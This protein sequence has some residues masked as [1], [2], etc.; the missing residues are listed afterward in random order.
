MAIRL[1][2]WWMLPL[3]P[4]FRDWPADAERWR[5][6]VTKPGLSRLLLCGACAWWSGL[7]GYMSDDHQDHRPLGMGQVVFLPAVN[8]HLIRDGPLRSRQ[9]PSGRLQANPREAA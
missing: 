5:R 3:L 4:Q 9:R 8:P 7:H 6:S 2:A 1:H